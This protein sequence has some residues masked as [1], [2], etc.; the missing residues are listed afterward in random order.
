M[1]V[2]RSYISAILA[3]TPHL[4]VSDA[5]DILAFPTWERTGA[6]GSQNC[7][8]TSLAPLWKRDQN[9][10]SPAKCRT[11]DLGSGSV[12]RVPF[13]LF[14]V[15]GA[16]VR[17]ACKILRQRNPDSLTRVPQHASGKTFSFQVLGNIFCSV[18]LFCVGQL[19]MAIWRAYV[20]S[21]MT[22]N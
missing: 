7:A 9:A 19:Y 10:I 14:N 15:H 2:G 11:L 3:A 16:A 22:F 13:P 4:K 18:N 12:E 1:G 5:P 8:V 21:P 17:C 6:Q 20:C